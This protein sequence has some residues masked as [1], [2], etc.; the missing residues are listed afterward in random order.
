MDKVSLQSAAER[1][2]ID[3]WGMLAERQAVQD[4]GTTHPVYSPGYSRQRLARHLVTVVVWEASRDFARLVVKAESCSL[5]EPLV[6]YW[7]VMVKTLL[8][9]FDRV[10]GRTLLLEDYLADCLQLVAAVA[11]LQQL[12]DCSV[13][14]TTAEP[15]RIAY[16]ETLLA[17]HQMN[18]S[19]SAAAGH[20]RTEHLALLETCWQ[21]EQKAHWLHWPLLEIESEKRCRCQV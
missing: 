17:A 8:D 14:G 7:S 20:Q 10:V 15:R 4:F 16:L 19:R 9:L 5:D 21:R 1:Q 18:S 13:V 6:A 3:Y 2:E 12:K 11:G